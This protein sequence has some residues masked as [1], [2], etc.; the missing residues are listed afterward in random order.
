MHPR[1]LIPPVGV[2]RLALADV[3]LIAVTS[4]AVVQTV[5][6]MMSSL[7]QI[8]FGAAILFSDQPPPPDTPRDITWQDIAPIRC[9][10]AYSQFMLRNLRQY[11]ATSHVLC[12]QWDG[13][14]L[15]ARRWD[16]EFLAYDYIGAPWPH[17]ADG[18]TVGNGGFSLRSRKLLDACIALGI[19]ATSE[20]VA[21]CR[22]NRLALEQEFGIR[23]APE[24]LA[25]RFA[26]ERHAPT[27][28]EF[29][30]HGAFNMVGLLNGSVLARIIDGLEPGLL[31]RREHRELLSFALRGGR[32][33]L[34]YTIA[35]R[36]LHKDARRL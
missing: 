10:A 13:Y 11:V 3:T 26:F 27:G 32:F 6:A 25:R 17:F 33:G 7:D 1:L 2:A 5:R 18:C 34:A 24:A 20:D 36:M 4:V 12:V 15:D 35:R 23:F 28:S 21:I 9:R 29:G 22:T 30:F 8:A 16:P 14:V 19:D 31:N